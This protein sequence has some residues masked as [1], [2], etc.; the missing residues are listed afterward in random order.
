M[1]KI[2]NKLLGDG[3]PT[4]IIAEAG[5]N[6]DGSLDQAYRLIDAAARAEADAVKF[7]VFRAE[8]L[9]PPSV[10]MVETPSG[11]IDFFSFLD[12][13][14]M[15]VHWL[16]KLARHAREQDILFLA[17]AFDEAMC[18]ALDNI[19]VPAHKIA[20]PELNHLPLIARM[21]QSGKPLMM[22]TG[23]SCLGDIEEALNIVRH[24]GTEAALLHCVSA[25]PTPPKDCNLRVIST[26]KQ[27]FQ[28][29][30]GFSDHTLHP[31][32]APVASVAL[33]ANIIE[34]H[35]TLSRK[36]DGPDH[37]FALEP[38]E[39]QQM[40][41]AIR[42]TESLSSLEK[43]KV[44]TSS[45][46]S[47]YLGCPVKKVTPSEAELALCDRRSIMAIKSIKKGAAISS[48]MVRILRAER[49]LRPGLSPKYWDLV[50]GKHLIRDV[51]SGQ[52]LQWDD[53]IS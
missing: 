32:K 6:H 48:D 19:G 30:V 33:G 29:P 38:N 1:I 17:T 13:M 34:K 45:D 7:Q 53:L 22:S 40:V 49:N 26:L 35:F 41:A 24:S 43:E 28:I 10:G 39:L 47:E 37:K 15:P 31:V 23:M 18:D 25:Y 52:G 42:E 44:L 4:F 11:S 14:S 50:C 5:S 36:L 16:D 27:T 8:Y 21:A 9:Y 2:G 20:S 12:N 46:I 51:P 3:C